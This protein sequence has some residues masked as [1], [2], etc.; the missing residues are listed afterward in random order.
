[1]IPEQISGWT[2][3]ANVVS[4][5]NH[6]LV[7]FKLWFSELS[8]SGK[9]AAVVVGVLLGALILTIALVA[10]IVYPKQIIDTIV[11]ILSVAFAAVLIAGL[12][13]CIFRLILWKIQRTDQEKDARRRGAVALEVAQQQAQ[14][15]VILERTALLQKI[16]DG[17][18]KPL[19][20]SGELLLRNSEAL[21]HRCSASVVSAKGETFSGNLFITSLRVVF[22]SLDYPLE[23]GIANI[24]AVN[25]TQ[26]QVQ[27]IAKTSSGTESFHVADPALV[28]AYIAR[29]V[30]TYHRQVDVGFEREGSRSVPQDVK[31]VV[32]QRDGGKCVQCGAADYL[33]YD[34]IIPFSKGGASSTDN[35]QLLCRRCNL[36]KRDAI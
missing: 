11:A 17:Q 8:E 14:S 15:S 26:G 13:Y 6:H 34:H 3:I 20:N 23:I 19:L 4:K 30:K 24:N 28:T 12:G 16:A 1:M 22:V 33:E 31:V 25:P 2:M 5:F 9:V 21:W 32:W 18:I 7:K 10:L 27:V 36:K 29:T 35:V